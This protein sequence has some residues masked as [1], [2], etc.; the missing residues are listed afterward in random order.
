MKRFLS[1]LFTIVLIVLP[2][3][4]CKNNFTIV[5]RIGDYPLTL[6]PQMA[7]SAVQLTV[8]QNA[9]EGLM[10][11]DQDGN[12]VP[13]AAS[14]YEVSRDGKTYTFTLRKGL[15]WSDG[16]ELTA[17]DF[18][19]GLKRATDP[20]THAPCGYL[21]SCIAGAKNRLAGGTASLGVSAPSKD[22]VVI[23]LIQADDSILQILSHP[24]ASPCNEEYF[25]E[26]NGKY[27]ITAKTVIS[28]GIYKIS[29]MTENKLIRLS[30]ND[31]YNGDIEPECIRAEFDF[32][33]LEEGS[34]LKAEALKEKW[35]IIAADRDLSAAAKEEGFH[36]YQDFDA[37]YFL[38]I[39]PK[40]T[41]GEK[42][43]IRR[44]LLLCVG[45]T[46]EQ[47]RFLKADTLLPVGLTINQK[48]IEQLDGFALWQNTVDLTQARRLFIGNASLAVRQTANMAGVVCEDTPAIE[49]V[50]KGIVSG[51]QE[52]LGTYC[53]IASAPEE[54]AEKKVADHDYSVALIKIA[55]QDRTA[56]SYLKQIVEYLGNP[57][58]LKTALD[59]FIAAKSEREAVTA[60]NNFAAV[61]Q[62]RSYGMPVLLSSSD[63]VY[64]KDFS[65]FV[66][67]NYGSLDFAYL[68]KK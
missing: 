10:R 4:G 11:L 18:V 44:A 62:A 6:D 5:C 30:L 13:G 36:L 7:E 15:C 58:D 64:N 50:L 46:D 56:G 40:S 67:T 43:E 19:Y 41:L 49:T 32:E 27:G 21:L 61:M 26:C 59:R 39:N 54:S 1:L 53:N 31:R 14:S 42:E 33:E 9:Y 55:S 23:Q 29:Y 52:H 38:L 48:P 12:A 28:N 17:G 66:K 47:S 8:C 22:K 60:A 68:R 37:T 51:W 20:A 65:G 25:K 24:V 2:L 45:K 57:D 3:S 16:T 34:D 63:Y 35:D